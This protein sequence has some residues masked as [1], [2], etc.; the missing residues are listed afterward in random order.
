MDWGS[1]IA[2]AITGVVGVAGIIGTA[3]QGKRSREAQSTDLRASI[4]AAA[5][6][7]RHSISVE[8]DRTKLADKSRI[9]AQCL[10]TLWEAVEAWLIHNASS[11]GERAITE[12]KTARALTVAANAAYSVRLIGPPDVSRLAGKALTSV[13]DRD[14]F[15][16]A[17]NALLF[18]MRADLGVPGEPVTSVGSPGQ[19]AD[20]LSGGG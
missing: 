5:E 11:G 19:S 13:R 10:A 14:S 20:P 18:A 6:N 1:V 8:D 15:P 4:D 3:W 2:G 16:G 12:L 9:Y 17:F 7:L